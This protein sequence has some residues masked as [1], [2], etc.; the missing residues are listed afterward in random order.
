MPMKPARESP[1]QTFHVPS[2]LHTAIFG[3]VIIV[4]VVNEF[5]IPHLRIDNKRGHDQ[6]EA[7]D[8]FGT[9]TS[10]VEIILEMG[11]V[12]EREAVY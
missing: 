3:D 1:G 6:K 12:F 5:M 10:H 11:I 9:V 8:D 7:D 4:V 2:G